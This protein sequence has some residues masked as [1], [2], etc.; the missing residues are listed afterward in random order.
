MMVG[1]DAGQERT[2]A[3]TVAEDD[4]LGEGGAV[5]DTSAGG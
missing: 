5:G 4:I 3:G 2:Q 1:G